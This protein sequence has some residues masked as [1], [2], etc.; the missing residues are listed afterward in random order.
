MKINAKTI[1][2]YGFLIAVSLIF[3]LVETLIPP[4]FAVPGMRLGLA[5]TVVLTALYLLGSKSAL[6][7]NL[8]R[9]LLVFLLFGNG[10]ALWFSLAGGLLSGI[11]M[12]LLKKTGKFS[13]TAVSVAGAVTHNIGQIAAAAILLGSRTVYWYLLL[14]WFSGIASGFL[15]GLLSGELCR[16]LQRIHFGGLTK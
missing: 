10:A 1:T 4:V 3:S 7:I 6:L 13:I 8:I 2:L 12:I 9:I 5:N 15:I 16:R 11:T 14:L